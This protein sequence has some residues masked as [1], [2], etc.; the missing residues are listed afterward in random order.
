M[1]AHTTGGVRFVA[2][3]STPGIWF[4]DPLITRFVPTIV[5][6]VGTGRPTQ[7]YGPRNASR[8][9]P[10]MFGELTDAAFVKNPSILGTTSI[11]KV[12]AAMDLQGFEITQGTCTNIGCLVI[13]DVGSVPVG[14]NAQTPVHPQSRQPHHH[15]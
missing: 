5:C 7:L 14:S 8:T 6:T 9:P 12:T 1:F 15:P 11:V 13:C 3:C 2:T 4:V 10:G